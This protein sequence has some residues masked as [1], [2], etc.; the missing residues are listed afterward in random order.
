MC[1]HLLNTLLDKYNEVQDIIAGFQREIQNAAGRNNQSVEE[2]D[3]KA[4]F[5]TIDT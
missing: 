3:D 1:N 4:I 5:K 2:G